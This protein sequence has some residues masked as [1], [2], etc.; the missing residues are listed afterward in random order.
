MSDQ[1]NGHDHDEDPPRDLAAPCCA[2]CVFWFPDVPRKNG[3][4]RRHSPVP[5]IAGMKKD[6]AGNMTPVLNAFFPPTNPDILCGEHPAF[7]P[8]LQQRQAALKKIAD[9]KAEAVGHG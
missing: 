7:F 9:A 4:C 8:W 1:A 2:N 3:N 5:M 6:F